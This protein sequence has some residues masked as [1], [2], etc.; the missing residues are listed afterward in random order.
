MKT[1]TDNPLQRK[2]DE[3]LR[4]YYINNGIEPR[5][6]RGKAVMGITE[7]GSVDSGRAK[8]SRAELRRRKNERQRKYRARLR[9]ELGKQVTPAIRE[10]YQPRTEAAQSMVLDH[11]PF[12]HMR[13][14]GVK[15]E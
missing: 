2:R 6:A 11:C 10:H 4:K 14:Y 1:V 7:N 9:K 13:F 12:C 3:E 5:T 15:G 8:T